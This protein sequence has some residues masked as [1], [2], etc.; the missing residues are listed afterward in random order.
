LTLLRLSGVLVVVSVLAAGLLLPYVG[1][2]GLVA[3]S[4]SDKFLNSTCDLKETAPPQGT[5]FYASDGA[6]VLATIFTQNRKPVALAQVP[7]FL[8]Q[9]LIDTEDRRF[10]EHHGVDMRSLMRSAFSTGSGDT[11]GGSTLTMQYVKQV[12]YYQA[13]GNTAAQEAAVSQNLNRKI[14]DAKCA[15]DLEQ[16]ESKQQILENYLNIAFFGENSYSVQAAAQTYFNKTVDKLTVPEAA[17]LVGVLRA[18]SE[19]DPFQ[20][21]QAAKQRRNQVLEN[22]VSAGHL[23]RADADKYEA[24]PIKLFTDQPPP[25]T[26]NCYNAPANVPNIGFFCDYVR[27]WLINTQKIS[28]DQIS[29]GGYKVI[30]TLN[31][32]VQTIAQNAVSAALPATSQMTALMPVV[33]PKTGNVLAMVSSKPYGVADGQLASSNVFTGYVANGASTYKYFTMLAALKAGITASF[34]LGNNSVDH[35]SYSPRSCTP[36]TVQNLAGGINYTPTETLASAIAK[37]SN[38]YFVGIEDQLFNT[39]DLSP[40]VNTAT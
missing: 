34:P 17:T 19:Y 23:S 4:E 8:Q 29:E 10:Y 28:S 36:G 30:T 1:G 21:A 22:M 33:D 13:I 9:A 31:V 18:P 32:G 35:K 39:C 3:K 27:N 11:Q 37:S 12:R 7:I 20:H 2:M 25:V 40:I 16:R 15:I 6:T 24:T 26:A 14:Q 5:T 38:T